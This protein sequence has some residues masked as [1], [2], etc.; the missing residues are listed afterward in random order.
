MTTALIRGAHVWGHG[1]VDVLISG[2]RIANIGCNLETGLADHVVEAEGQILY[3]GLV[4]THHHSAQSI[5]KGMSAGI[6]LD[7][8]DWLAA[9]P[10]AVWPHVTPETVYVAAR[11]A[12]AELLRAGCTTCADHHYLYHATTSPEAEQAL[13]QA[14]HEMGIR[15]VLC[16]GS[17]TV[18]GTH[19]G[20]SRAG[21]QPESIDL[22]LRRLDDTVSRYHDAAEDAMS[23]VVVA[24]TSLVHSNPPEH[25][26]SLRDFAIA[27][28]LRRHSHL[29]EVSH[30]ETVCQQVHGCS[31]VDYAESLG[32]VEDDVW[33]AHLVKLDS[34]GIQ[35]FAKAGTGVSH[36]PSSNC[37]LGSGIAR[38]PEMALAG[39]P[40]SIGVD[41]SASAESGSPVTEMM[42]SW[43]LHR[44]VGGP[45][46]TRVEQI[47]EWA[48]YGGAQIL[49][50]SELGRIET[51]QLADLVLYDLSA[52]RFQGLW[53]PE[54]APVICGEPVSATAV[55]VNGDWRVW[56]GE[57]TG[58]DARQLARDAQRERA[59]LMS[60]CA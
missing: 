33:F 50:Y 10:Y 48:T 23:R 20:F 24:P 21:F 38:V 22:C 49:G 34:D 25:L 44:A 29:L 35:R 43:L 52:P 30:D 56:D 14:A 58:L 40:V 16:R 18:S 3:P 26:Q 2:A 46:A 36:C 12:F 15:L 5:S 13:F 6:D 27:K 17:S 41:G 55:M 28:G 32:W 8:G 31:A 59:R 4:N 60:Q 51:G 9:V 54:W 47:V 42:L 37:R 39:M 57:I 11:I 19:R 7:L 45:T 1:S 53:Q